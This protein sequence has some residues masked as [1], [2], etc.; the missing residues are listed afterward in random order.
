MFKVNMA[1]PYFSE[2]DRIWI[3]KEVD[4][5]LN[6][7]LSMGPNVQL[8]EAEFAQYINVKHAIAVN[9]CTTALEIA[10]LFHDIKGKEVI[11]PA[12]TFIA[13]G[14]AVHL[15]GGIPV[16]AEISKS[17]FC[18]DLNDVEKRISSKT[19]GIIL[20]H[21]AGL[22][23]PN[24]E[25][26]KRFCDERGLFLIEDAAHSP[27]ASLY[28]KKA[29]S[30][31]H[32][33]C[34]SFFPTKVIT[35]GEGGMLT[36][37]CNDMASF[38]RS[39]QHRGRDLCEKKELYIR[40][41]RNSRMTEMAALLGRVQL[42]H[43]DEFLQ[44]RREIALMYEKGLKKISDIEL[45][46]PTTDFNASSFWKVV[47][48]LNQ[49]IDR[50]HI[51]TKM[52]QAG[53]A[54]DWAYQPALHLQPVFKNLYQT[55]EGMLPITENLLSRHLCLPCHPRMTNAEVMFVAETLKETL[56]NYSHQVCT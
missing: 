38:A 10:L 46:F 16:F 15:A 39:L 8:F 35:A 1:A 18:L 50:Q 23:T 56:L 21:M 25:D 36:T 52:H 34:F 48:L 31:G 51:T 41:G 40:A 37:N 26:F 47:V 5:I 12:E 20:V 4:A 7:A 3:H 27:G 14:M 42:S 2:A 44:R 45:I 43:I 49:T 55:K 6:G 30:F 22:I 53:I 24:I 54:V 32:V 19:A 29:G 13:T 17:T 11:L 28:H 33:G 9:S